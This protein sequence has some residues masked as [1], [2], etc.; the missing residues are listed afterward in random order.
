MGTGHFCEPGLSKE[1]RIQ[2]S[3]AWLPSAGAEELAAKRASCAR[4]TGRSARPHTTFTSARRFRF[5][6]IS[7]H[8]VILL[9]PLVDDR[10]IRLP[11]CRKLVSRENCALSPLRKFEPGDE[12]LLRH[13]RRTA[14]NCPGAA[15]DSEADRAA[16]G[17][18]SVDTE[19]SSACL[20]GE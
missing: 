1:V 3:E 11:R 10:C 18:F 6:S 16:V 2:P 8:A 12:P 19:T 15:R 17:D 7:A 14:A 13:V 9:V 5:G 20:L 4:R